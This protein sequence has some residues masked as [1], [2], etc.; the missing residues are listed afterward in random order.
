MNPQFIFEKK[1]TLHVV[2]MKWSIII[3]IDWNFPM[4]FHD[5]QPAQEI[6]EMKMQCGLPR[7]QKPPKQIK[8]PQF[9][10]IL[11]TV[12]S[13]K[14]H[15]VSWYQWSPISAGTHL[16]FLWFFCFCLFFWSYAF[17]AKYQSRRMS[18]ICYERIYELV[19]YFIYKKLCNVLLVDFILVKT[20]NFIAAS[21][22]T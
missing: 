12:P 21:G 10:C 19:Y 4:L 20:E 11:R 18:L 16:R 8:L 13:L 22:K 9:R 1:K 7:T 15:F 14:P 5:D 3:Q 6:S 2:R 17:F